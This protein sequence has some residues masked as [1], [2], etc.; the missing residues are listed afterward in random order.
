[1]VLLASPPVQAPPPLLS[2]FTAAAISAEDAA[3]S[4]HHD[5]KGPISTPLESCLEV[6]AMAGVDG[7]AQGKLNPMH[8][9]TGRKVF[10]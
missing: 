2:A 5:G 4:D 6:V 3:F 8:L 7:D 1:M 10:E 9:Y